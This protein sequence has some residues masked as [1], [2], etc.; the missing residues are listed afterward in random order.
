MPH[1]V[2]VVISAAGL[3]TRLGLNRPKA[4]APVAGRTILEWQ[5]EMLR[6]VDDVVIVAGFQASAVAALV[7]SVRPEAVICLNHDFAST[8]TA[9]SLARG[10]R[11]ANDWVISLDGDLLV[12]Q[13]AFDRLLEREGPCL[14]IIPVA[15]MSPVFAT[16]DRGH[17]VTSLSQ[18]DETEWEWTGLAK[19]P[20]AAA[21]GLGRGHV[22]IGLKP[23]L[24]LPSEIIECVEVDEVEDLDRAEA[25]LRHRGGEQ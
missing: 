20:R 2:T 18:T 1:A 15:S 4:L 11:I 19:I 25:W 10:A 8:G 24:P 17:N 12:D 7:R 22:F 5:L 14:G 16:V 6:D 13:E 9:A 23:H 21:V 3:G